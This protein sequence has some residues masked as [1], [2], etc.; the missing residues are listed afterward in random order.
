[1]RLSTEARVGLVVL[2]GV[3]ILTYM[4]FKVG[5]YRFGTEA[6]YRIFAL[7]DTVAGLDTKSKIRVAGV[8]VG[9]VETIT[10]LDGQAKVTL[11]INPDIKLRKGT[12]AAVRATGL[13]GDKYLELVPGKEEGY[14]KDGDSIPQSEQVADLDRLINQFSSIAT[15]IK[16]VSASLREALGTKEGE[17]SMKEIVAN[18]RDLSHNLSGAVKDNREN[19]TKAVANIQD[20]SASLKT[21]LPKLMESLNRT[22]EK[23]E[24]IATKVEKGEGTLGKLV[25]NDDVYNKLDSA[26]QGLNNITQKVEKGEGTI[27]KLFT[28]DKAYDQITTALEGFGNAVNRIERFKTTIG[29]RNEYQLDT[30]ENKGYF[31]V[32]LQPRE[33]KFYLLELVDDPRGRVIKTITQF[34]NNGPVTQYETQHRLKFSAEF[35]R[36]F[37]DLALRVG[38]MENSFGG[39]ADLYLFNDAL[40]LSADIWDFNSDDPLNPHP[41]IKT[42]AGYTFFKYLFV[43]GGYDNYLNR[44]LDTGFIGGG[45]RFED[46]DLKY[47]LGSGALRVR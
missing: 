20:V 37:S 35:G 4:T 30:H 24:A 14:L 8:E 31:S 34:D 19:F 17:T 3:L 11:R 6:G 47:L 23:L 9:Q 5:G 26:L 42:T 18:I 27:G 13:L 25:Q 40:K 36:R 41:H 16:A 12:Q 39:G 33:D 45:L 43:Q 15:D 2:L 44:K 28:D 29:F 10:L 38:L 22:S 21:D 7:F 1:M 46:D 32:Q